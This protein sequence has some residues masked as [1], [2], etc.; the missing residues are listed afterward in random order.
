MKV[1][2]CA[3][4]LSSGW[5]LHSQTR[6]V[7][8]PHPFSGHDGDGDDLGKVKELGLARDAM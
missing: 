5:Q 8:E 6:R 4:L 2:E 7:L 3:A 1:R